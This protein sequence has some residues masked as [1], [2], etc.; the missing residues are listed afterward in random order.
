M[1]GLGQM[2]EELRSD[3]FTSGFPFLQALLLYN[4]DFIY[5]ICF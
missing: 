1:D 4:V 3:T 2:G 5:V